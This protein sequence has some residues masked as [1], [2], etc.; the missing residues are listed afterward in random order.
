M[1]RAHP[2]GGAVKV[3]FDDFRRARPDEEELPNVRPT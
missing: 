2:F 1:L 3:K